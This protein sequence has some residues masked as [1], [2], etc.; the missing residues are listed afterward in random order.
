M[1]IEDT[2]W[3]ELAIHSG[4]DWDGKDRPAKWFMNEY[5]LIIHTTGSGLPDKAMKNG[6]YPTVRAERHYSRSHGCHLINGYRGHDGGDLIQM[7]HDGERASGVGT[8]RQKS[9]PNQK[10]QH[11]SIL[12]KYKGDW[13]KDLPASLVKRLE[14]QWPGYPNPLNLLPDSPNACCVH[15]ECP[16]LTKFWIAQGFE[17]AFPGSYFTQ[18]QYDT[19]AAVGVD[20]A[21]RK[22]W[23]WEWWRMPRLLGHED[24]TPISRHD[25]LGGWDPGALRASPR[26][27]WRLVIDEVTKILGWEAEEEDYQKLPKQGSGGPYAKY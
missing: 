13:R 5:G 24:L 19:I 2:G 1:P 16:P 23:P 20:Y 12:G 4:K 17:P 7:A 9:K 25:K 26:F 18:A 8:R 21:A 6:Q 3:C 15:M 11:D 27:D 10:A 14:E 22:Q